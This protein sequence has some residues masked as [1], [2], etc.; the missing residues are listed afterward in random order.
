ML[1]ACGV[2]ADLVVTGI[3]SGDALDGKRLGD[4]FDYLVDMAIAAEI[5]RGG[6]A[7]HQRIRQIMKS[8]L[9]DT[10]INR[11][12]RR[13]VFEVLF[14]GQE[15]EELTAQLL[16]GLASTTLRALPEDTANDWIA[17]NS[18]AL[19]SIGSS[20]SHVRLQG[21]ALSARTGVEVRESEWG[22]TPFGVRPHGVSRSPGPC[23]V[24]DP[25]VPQKFNPPLRPWRPMRLCVRPLRLSVPQRLRS[26][27]PGPAY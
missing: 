27:E 14:P 8:R 22:L 1:E 18:S 25:G 23:R 3:E 12:S 6:R 2:V 13:E 16:T 4:F 19:R 7:E 15:I 26:P 9:R 21:A 10:F 5:C 17:K 11:F 24:S 20:D